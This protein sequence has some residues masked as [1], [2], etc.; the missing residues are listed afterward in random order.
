MAECGNA[1]GKTTL[2]DL[3]RGAGHDIHGVEGE[4]DIAKEK[5][6]REIL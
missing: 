4:R 6:H 3:S 1:Q 5:V 2:G